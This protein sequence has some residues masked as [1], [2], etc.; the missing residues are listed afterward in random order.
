M[1][2]SMIMVELTLSLCQ[3]LAERKWNLP[4]PAGKYTQAEIG[5]N[6]TYHA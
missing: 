6:K 3:N 1:I 4:P 2:G 5:I